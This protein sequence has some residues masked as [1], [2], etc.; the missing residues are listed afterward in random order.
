MGFFLRTPP[1]DFSLI[2]ENALRTKCGQGH[3]RTFCRAIGRWFPRDISVLRLVCTQKPYQ[4][5]FAFPSSTTQ[6]VVCTPKVHLQDYVEGMVNMYFKIW[7]M[8]STS[9]VLLQNCSGSFAPITSSTLSHWMSKDINRYLDFLRSSPCHMKL[10]WA[11]K[12]WRL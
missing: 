3:R 4:P 10:L 7:T 8:L 9:N 1:L 6:E 5:L 11:K 2:N 12:D